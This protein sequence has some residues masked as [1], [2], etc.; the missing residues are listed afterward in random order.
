M[1]ALLLAGGSGTRLW[2]LSRSGFPKQF[3]KLSGDDSLLQQTIRR[4]MLVVSADD[5]VILTN[6]QYKFHVKSDI[7][8]MGHDIVQRV[9]IVLEPALRNTAAAIAL[10]IKYC[11]DVLGCGPDETVFVCPSDHIIRPDDRFADYLKQ[12]TEITAA[13]YIVTFG[14][15]P[16]KPE[17]GYGYIQRG[18]RL[19]HSLKGVE[20]YEV[21]RFTEKPDEQTAQT[22]IED[23]KHFWNAGIFAFNIEVMLEEFNKHIP[24][25]SQMLGKGY[26]EMLASFAD[27]PNKSIDYAVMERSERIATLALDIYWNDVGSWDSLFEII[28]RDADGNVKKGD[29]FT[30]DTKDTMILGD[31]RLTVTIGIENCMVLET[32]DVV[33]ISKRGHAQK[34]KDVVTEL[35]KAGRHEVNEHVTTYRPWGSYTILESGERYKIKRLMVNP[36]ACISLQMHHHRSEHWVVVN[37]TAKVIVGEREVF[38]HVNESAFV[39]KSTKHRLENPGIIPLEVIEVQNGEYLEEDDI[40]RFEDIYDRQE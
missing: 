13:G 10:G 8:S 1:K 20:G 40:I 34:V 27:M 6:Q 30:F 26:R 12:A 22:Y 31:N 25:I 29:V 33:L 36:K 18:S 28:E 15:K 24:A 37:G 17:T 19:K 9:H 4:L 21:E 14:V 32:D 35:R 7:S 39:P 11:Q 3:L 5:I 38:V 2:P 23:G 16:T